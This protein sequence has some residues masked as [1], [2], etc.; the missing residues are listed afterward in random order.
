M[1]E[2]GDDLAGVVNEYRFGKFM[3]ADD[4]REE[5]DLE[6]SGL[7]AEFAEGTAGDARGDPNGRVRQVCVC[8]SWR[9]DN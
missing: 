3:T 4:L 9:Q 2:W 7:C 6:R 8:I 1:P 5:R